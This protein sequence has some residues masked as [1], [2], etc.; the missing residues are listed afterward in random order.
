MKKE[1]IIIKVLYAL[2]AL[3]YI[4]FL[5]T[6]KSAFMF[7]GGLLMI[8]ASIMLNINNKDKKNK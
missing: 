1:E 3:G 5:A 2:S 8:A 6:N 7:C 4:T